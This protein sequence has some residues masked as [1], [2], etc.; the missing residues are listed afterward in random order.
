MFKRCHAVSA[1][2]I[3][4]LGLNAWAGDVPD[5]QG[6]TLTGDWGGARS[7]LSERGVDFELVHKSDV[8]AVTSGGIKRGARWMGNTE[9]MAAMD[10]ETMLGWDGMTAFVHFHAQHGDKFDRDHVGSFVG[11]DNIENGV[12]TGQFDNAWIQ[13]SFADGRFSV[14]AGL[15]AVDTEF[16]ITESSGVFIQPPYGPG[17]EFAQPLLSDSPQSPPVFPLGA[18]AVRAKY[19]SP[20]SGLYVQ[21]ALADGVPG[22]PDNPKGTHVK[23]RKRDGSLSIVEIGVA[24]PAPVDGAGEPVEVFNKVAFGAWRYS[25]RVD[26]PLDVD[27]AGNPVRRH[28]S[29]AYVVAERTLM[30]ESGTASQG[31]AGFVRFGTASEELYQADWTASVGLRYRGLVPGRDDDVLGVAATVNHASRSYRRLV[32]AER[33]QTTYE[34]TYRAQI[35][36]WLAL[37][38]TVQYFKDPNM[39]PAQ[40]NAWVVGARAEIAF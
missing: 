1:L 5:W 33:A 28:S 13:K 37:M 39:D 4:T 29:G 18:L 25:K 35:N 21:Y 12:N 34:L 36:P 7:W 40:R 38:P 19:E 17:N 20:E 26:D 15:Y 22:N 16:Y 14:L 9:A 30:V 10:L 3:S 32:G 8:L 2:L 23:V 27:G 24:P 6:S 11:V 31:L